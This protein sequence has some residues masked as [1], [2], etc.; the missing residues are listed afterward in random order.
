[1]LVDDL[2]TQLPLIVERKDPTW[3]H[4]RFLQKSLG[5]DVKSRRRNN[6]GGWTRPVN[7]KR[8]EKRILEAKKVV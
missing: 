4:T 3:L 6:S 7:D 5:C 8:K 2:K 1:L